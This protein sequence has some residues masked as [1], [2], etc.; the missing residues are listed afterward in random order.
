MLGCREVQ[1]RAVGSVWYL[2]GEALLEIKPH[3]TSPTG[4]AQG[5]G[6]RPKRALSRAIRGIDGQIWRVV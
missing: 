1:A 3:L 6:L 4:G 2:A 5:L